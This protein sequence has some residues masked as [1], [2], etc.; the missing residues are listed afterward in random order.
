MNATSDVVSAWKDI[1]TGVIPHNTKNQEKQWKAWQR[2]STTWNIDPFLQ[3]CD[4]ID[5]I[6]VVTYFSAR[7]RKGYYDKDV[8]SKVNCF[9][10]VL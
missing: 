8:Q 2:Y 6:I 7:V 10:K 1:D 5:I 3:G 4:H 9:A